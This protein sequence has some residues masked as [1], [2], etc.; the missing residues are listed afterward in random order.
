VEG[1]LARLDVL[2]YDASA[3]ANTGQLRAELARAGT[4]VGAYDAMIAGHA[5][6]QGHATPLPSPL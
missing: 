6:S 2:D 3:A 1:F 5:R 4:P